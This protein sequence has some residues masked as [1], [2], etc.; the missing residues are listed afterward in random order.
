MKLKKVGKTTRLLRYEVNQ[1][2]YDYILGVTKRVKGIDLIDRESEKLWTEVHD[3]VEKAVIKT[4]PKKNKCKKSKWLSE[5]A[6]Q[7]A[8]KRKE[9]K[10]KREKENIYPYECRV[11]KNSKEK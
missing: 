4:I 11:P 5:E 9:A 1:S 3:I 6:I 8:E 2:P 10:G 7:I